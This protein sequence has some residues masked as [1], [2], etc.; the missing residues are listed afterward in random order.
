[1]RGRKGKVPNFSFKKLFKNTMKFFFFKFFQKNSLPPATFHLSSQFS[2]QWHASATSLLLLLFH[3]AV[4][5]GVQCSERK[6]A[7]FSA[8]PDR[9]RRLCDRNAHC[10]RW[11]LPYRGPVCSRST[12]FLRTHYE[13][14]WKEY[15]FRL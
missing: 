10:A 2:A 14:T 13:Y 4:T 5:S 11:Q 7:T 6:M 15:A 8:I 12:L 1:M 3:S 9:F